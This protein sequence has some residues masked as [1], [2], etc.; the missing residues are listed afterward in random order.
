MK[1]EIEINGKNYS[2]TRGLRIIIVFVFLG[3]IVWDAF[4]KDWNAVA[5][6]SLFLLSVLQGNEI[7]DLQDE[8]EELKDK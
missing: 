2:F 1:F 4:K 7:T 6:D 5:I 3:F 8:I